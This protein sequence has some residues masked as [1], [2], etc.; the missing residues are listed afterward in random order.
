MKE[1][2]EKT[3]TDTLSEIKRRVSALLGDRLDRIVLYGSRARGDYDKNSDIDVAIIVKDLDRETKNLVLETVAEVELHYLTP[4]SALV[5][6]EKSFHEL[7]ERER[8][9]ALDIERE[10]VPL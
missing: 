9:I 8:R 4:V 5:M 1:E 2:Y 7:L 10:G 3:V 6:S